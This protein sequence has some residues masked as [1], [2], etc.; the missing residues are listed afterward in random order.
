MSV[1]SVVAGWFATPWTP[2]LWQRGFF[3][4]NC[5]VLRR[6][7][8][9]VRKRCRKNLPLSARNHLSNPYESPQAHEAERQPIAKPFLTRQRV[10]WLGLGGIVSAL[11]M[12][13]GSQVLFVESRRLDG[14]FYAGVVAIDV[15]AAILFLGGVIALIVYHWFPDPKRKFSWRLTHADKPGQTEL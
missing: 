13:T 12:V 1:R 10:F 9:S 2:P 8:P 3:L 11:M 5:F 7:L 15:I 4:V 6:F 14:A